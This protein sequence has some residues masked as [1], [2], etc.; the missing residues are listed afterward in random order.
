MTQAR[1]V[2]SR[3]LVRGLLVQAAETDREAMAGLEHDRWSRW[4]KYQFSKGMFNEDGTWTMPAE[5]VERWQR[6]M[7]TPYDELSEEEKDSD[8]R[9]VDQTLALLRGSRGA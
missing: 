8:R 9:E 1:R 4:M 5:A 6:Q 3:Y 2:A 7:D